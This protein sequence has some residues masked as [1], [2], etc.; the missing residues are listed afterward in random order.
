VVGAGFLA[1]DRHVVTCA[2]VVN[3]ALGRAT[4]EIV[5][6]EDE[7]MIEFPFASS[8]EPIPTRVLMDGWVPVGPREAGDVAVLELQGSPPGDVRLPSDPW[9]LR[10]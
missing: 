3:R 4:E 6:P 10:L 9:W 7:V 1:D 2:H 8:T 5:L